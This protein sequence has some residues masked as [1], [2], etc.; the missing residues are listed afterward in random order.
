M[1]LSSVPRVELAAPVRVSQTPGAEGVRVH[2]ALTLFNDSDKPLSR[3]TARVAGPDGGVLAET[4]LSRL[5]AFT[6][7][8]IVIDVPARELLAAMATDGGA[9][10]LPSVAAQ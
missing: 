10:D 2:I 4:I 6:S 3:V 1:R 7:Q 8:A 9:A 5:K